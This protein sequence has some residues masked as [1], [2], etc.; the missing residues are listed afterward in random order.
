M[1][2]EK[3]YSYAG[4]LSCWLAQDSPQ[5]RVAC[6][7]IASGPCGRPQ[8]QNVMVIRV[9]VLFHSHGLERL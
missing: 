6:G 9:L 2:I 7:A 5:H 4:D 3:N 8:W 1:F